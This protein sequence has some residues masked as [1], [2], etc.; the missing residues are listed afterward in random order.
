MKKFILVSFS[1]ISGILYMLSWNLFLQHFDEYFSLCIRVL[2][3]I[4]IS[5][6]VLISVISEK[7][8]DGIVLAFINMFITFI[9]VFLVAYFIYGVQSLHAFG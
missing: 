5:I 2:F 8:G 7:D 3:L 9:I 4:I 1:A 6:F